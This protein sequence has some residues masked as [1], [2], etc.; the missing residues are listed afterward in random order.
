MLMLKVAVV[1]VKLVV[2]MTVPFCTRDKEVIP[3]GEVPVSVRVKL[4]KVA[5]F[6]PGLVS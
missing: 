3:T 6:P 1:P 4:V 2:D 5:L